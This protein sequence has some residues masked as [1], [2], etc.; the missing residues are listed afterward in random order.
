M[1]LKKNTTCIFVDLFRIYNSLIKVGRYIRVNI[2]WRG[3]ALAPSIDPPPLKI[4]NNNNKHICFNTDEKM[5]LAG[6]TGEVN[7]SGYILCRKHYL[8]NVLCL[9]LC[10]TLSGSFSQP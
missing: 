10:E 8:G 3:G 2:S 4:T 5:K 9:L 1:Y 7:L 6:H